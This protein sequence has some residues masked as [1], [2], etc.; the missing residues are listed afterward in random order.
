[1]H[2]NVVKLCA[3]FEL[4]LKFEMM[5]NVIDAILE[6]VFLVKIYAHI[7]EHVVNWT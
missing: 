3:K 1:M 5:Y 6:T 2:N 4:D 7:N